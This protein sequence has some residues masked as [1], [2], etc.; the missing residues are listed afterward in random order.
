MKKRRI[1]TLERM[2]RKPIGS[3][4]VIGALGAGVGNKLGEYEDIEYYEAPRKTLLYRLQGYLPLQDD[5][6]LEVYQS[7]KGKVFM[8]SLCTAL[9]IMMAGLGVWALLNQGKDLFDSNAQDYVPK[10]NIAKNTDPNKIAIPGY[11]N[12][13]MPEGT[14]SHISLWNPEGNPC[15]FKF[16]I[17]MDET[18]EVLYES[19]LVEP[20]KAVIEQTLSKKL[21]AGEYP[22]TIEIKSY[23]LDDPEKEMNGGEVQTNLIVVK[24]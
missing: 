20:G 6:Y 19:K 4:R 18:K 21:K 7:R 5:E 9:L 23:S 15:Y 10:T 17:V 14:S 2:K 8:V 12:I 3:Y 13:R 11:Q 22:I 16:M 1:V 24:P